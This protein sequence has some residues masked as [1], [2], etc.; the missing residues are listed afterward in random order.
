[1]YFYPN[2]LQLSSILNVEQRLH[3]GSK[4]W[5]LLIHFV[6]LPCMNTQTKSSLFS[7]VL[8]HNVTVPNTTG[9]TGHFHCFSFP[10][11]SD[12]PQPPP[13]LDTCSFE[14]RTATLMTD[15][16]A[17]DHPASSTASQC[18]QWWGSLR[19]QE[20]SMCCCIPTLINR[21]REENPVQ[22]DTP[23]WKGW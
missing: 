15:T 5:H 3:F 17:T 2:P 11:C 21:V 12:K 13:W 18:N 23:T 22:G 4:T 8:N 14:I 20:D 6:F 7:E 1:M 9:K 10:L 16:S 19:L